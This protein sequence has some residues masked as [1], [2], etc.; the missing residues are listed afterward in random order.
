MSTKYGK[1]VVNDNSNQSDFDQNIGFPQPQVQVRPHFNQP[2]NILEGPGY[3]L[4]E[5]QSQVSKWRYYVNIIGWIFIVVGSLGAF[6]NLIG[7]IFID[8]QDFE[9]RGPKNRYEEFDYPIGPQIVDKALDAMAGVSTFIPELP[10]NILFKL[11]IIRC[12][13]VLGISWRKVA[14]SPTR[15]DT[16]TLCKKAMFI[17]F[18]QVII[19]VI[20]FFAECVAM[21]MVIQKW[22]SVSFGDRGIIH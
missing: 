3:K 11:F 17:A 21:S 20:R 9:I 12:T 8:S 19:L 14:L 18:A 7:M 22:E 5:A 10:L 4:F 2:V 1:V 6:A 13:V 15:A 16:W